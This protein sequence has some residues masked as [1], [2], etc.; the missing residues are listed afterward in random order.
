[1][2]LAWPPKPP[3]AETRVAGVEVNVEIGRKLVALRSQIQSNR[4]YGRAVRA[5]SDIDTPC[6]PSNARAS[7]GPMPAATK[8]SPGCRGIAW[9]GCRRHR[10]LQRRARPSRARVIAGEIS[11]H[12]T[13]SGRARRRTPAESRPIS[14]RAWRRKPAYQISM[15]G[16]SGAFAHLFLRQ[17]IEGALNRFVGALALI[18]FPPCLLL[19]RP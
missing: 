2:T 4:A 9:S 5:Q 16:N 6:T 1:M 12:P 19:R 3:R 7:P 18:A 15:L 13:S 10:C 8:S 17:H 11:S 14:R